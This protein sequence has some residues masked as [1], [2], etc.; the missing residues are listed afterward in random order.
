VSAAHDFLYTQL[1]WNFITKFHEGVVVQKDGIL[2]R[3]FVYRAP[4]VDSSGEFEV[5]GL[6]IRVNDFAKRLGTGWAF[7]VEAQRF[8]TTEYPVASSYRAG[9]FDTLA[10]YLIDRERQASFSSGKHYESSYFLTFTWRP[11][12]E[13]I[14]KLTS[15]FIQS[16]SE[17]GSA[18]NIRLV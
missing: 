16:S 12:A 15:M 6:C 9:G 14:K 1:P 11:P 5:N 8:H 18:K 2:Q 3:T 10:G 13:G 4:D 17:G 7:F